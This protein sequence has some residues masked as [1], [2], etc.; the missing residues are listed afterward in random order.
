[1]NAKLRRVDLFCKLGAPLAV[2][3]IAIPLSVP[4]TML[5]VCACAL[6]SIPIELSLISRMF[7]DCP[8]LHLRARISDEVTMSEPTASTAQPSTSSTSNNLFNSWKTY[9]THRMFLASLSLALLYLTTLSFGNVMIT[10][11][12]SLQYS[13][14]FLAIMRSFSVLAGLLATYTA[15]V[16]IRN[17]G[18][19]KTGLISIWSQ[20]LCLI[21]VLVSFFISD[22]PSLQ[23]FLFFAGIT[24]S[25]VGLWSF[26]MSEMELL[27]KHVIGEDVGLFNGCEFSLQNWFELLS[28]VVTMV[29]SR[30]DE[31]W[32]SAFVTVG[33][34]SLAA[35]CFTAFVVQEAR[36]HGGVGRPDER[37][38]LLQE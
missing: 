5:V 13:P 6:A 38:V 27:Q 18:L 23:T 11:L 19:P 14:T 3:L 21:P 31:F 2:S 1:M 24:F 15:P 35:L 4:E 28:Y 7:N 20:V 22:N 37:T 10:Y 32:V 34:V 33:S 30:A 25:R 12:I 8:G 16:L 36:R 9:T 29:W 26:D 17:I